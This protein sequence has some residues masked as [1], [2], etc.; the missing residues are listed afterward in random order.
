[1]PLHLGGDECRFE[2]FE[3]LVLSLDPTLALSA[4]VW[5]SEAV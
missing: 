5:P 1:M 4:G 3:P 2:Q